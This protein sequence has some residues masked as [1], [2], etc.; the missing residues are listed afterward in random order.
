MISII[1][2]G[3]GNIHSL[4]GAIKKIAPS[5]EVIISNDPNIISE[6]K[7]IFLPG[8]GHFKSAMESLDSLDLNNL[9]R[10]LVLVENKPIMGICLGMQL[11]FSTST[12]GGLI[13]GLNLIPGEVTKLNTGKDK[14]PH[15]GFNSVI[16]PIES[17]M[18]NRVHSYD[19]YFVHS[20]CVHELFLNNAYIAYCK[21]NGEFV[22]AVEYEH[23]WG[24]QFH[25]EKSQGE[26]LR[27]IKNF[28]DIYGK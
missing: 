13:N 25:P 21:C 5:L 23:I 14:I 16:P 1:D 3:M 17:S 28:I 26:G 24:T 6:S 2:Y 10:N 12:E 9:I 7:L 8:V 22:A 19:F 18:F 20:Y 11:L 27:I 4:K 15:I